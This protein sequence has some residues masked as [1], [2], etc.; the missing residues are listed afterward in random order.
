MVARLDGPRVEAGDGAE[1]AERDEDDQD[2]EGC[3]VHIVLSG[4]YQHKWS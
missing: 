4:D 1:H 2:D 3:H